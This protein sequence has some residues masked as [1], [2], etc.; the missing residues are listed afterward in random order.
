MF[1]ITDEQSFECLDMWYSSFLAFASP[2]EPLKFPFVLIGNKLDKKAGREVSQQ[3]AKD[4]C[5]SRGDI[6]YFETSASDSKAVREAFEGAIRRFE[7]S[8]STRSITDHGLALDS[9]LKLSSLTLK[10]RKKHPCKC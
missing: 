2:S 3:Q 7:E 5:R 9:S 10:H 8:D 6:P 4:W 1:D